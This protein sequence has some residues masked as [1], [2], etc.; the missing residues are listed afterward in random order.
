[1]AEVQFFGV[2]A[3]GF[4]T[5]DAQILSGTFRSQAEVQFEG[6]APAPS[7]TTA[8]TIVTL[9]TPT[10]TDRAVVVFTGTGG[11]QFP[12]LSLNPNANELIY[13]VDGSSSQDGAGN[14]TFNVLVA[15]I[16]PDINNGPANPG[17]GTTP[18]LDLLAPAKPSGICGL[19]AQFINPTGGGSTAIFTAAINAKGEIVAFTTNSLTLKGISGLGITSTDRLILLNIDREVRRTPVLEIILE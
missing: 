5:P 12:P 14:I 16:L 4:Q 15:K 2:G 13:Y 11:S 9:N 1:M 17:P 7:G 10:F 19:T 6:N 8:N 18:F 3:T